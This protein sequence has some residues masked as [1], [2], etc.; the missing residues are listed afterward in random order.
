MSV[1]IC[2]SRHGV[3]YLDIR[4]GKGL[5]TRQSTKLKD[6]L[7]NRKLL[8]ENTIPIILVQIMNGEYNP[9]A[10]KTIAPKILKEYGYLSLKRHRNNRRVHVHDDYVRHFETKIVPY[11]GNYL[12]QNISAMDLLDWQL[13]FLA[14]YKASSVK[15][16]RTVFNGILE[17]ACKEVVIMVKN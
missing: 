12:V 4:Y 16:Y 5:R 11:F 6:T 17:D 15:K 9:K 3:L 13:D 10:S 14:T 2:S 7:K 1:R 8:E